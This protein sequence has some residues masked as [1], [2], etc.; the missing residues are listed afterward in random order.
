MI[1]LDGRTALVTGGSRGIGRAVAVMLARAG[2]DVA[3]G[4]RARSAEAEAVAGEIRGLGRRAIACG[5]DLADQAAADRMAA[6]V[7]RP[8]RHLRG[9]RRRV[10]TG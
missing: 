2:A 1:A 4:Y 9:Q 5:G 8:A 3:I 6:E 7:V 10:A